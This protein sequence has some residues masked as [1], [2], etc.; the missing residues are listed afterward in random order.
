MVRRQ[1]DVIMPISSVHIKCT[2][3]FQPQV[4]VPITSLLPNSYFSNGDPALTILE[5]TYVY[6]VTLPQCQDRLL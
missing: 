1:A 6:H 2:L 4:M 5:S 3:P